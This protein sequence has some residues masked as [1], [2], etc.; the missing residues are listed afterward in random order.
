D[1]L[2]LDPQRRHPRHVLPDLHRQLTQGP[3]ILRGGLRR[4]GGEGGPRRRGGAGV[5]AGRGLR[6]GSTVARAPDSSRTLGSGVDAKALW[7]DRESC[8]TPSHQRGAAPTMG[9]VSTGTVLLAEPRGYCA[10]VDR[11]VVAV[12]RALEHYDET[13]YVRH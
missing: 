11:A 13:I 6:H 8:P 5:R 2:A 3:G 1:D 10:G 12:E 7:R 9:G 4:G